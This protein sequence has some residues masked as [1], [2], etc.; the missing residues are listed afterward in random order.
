MK[1]N[2]RQKNYYGGSKKTKSFERSEFQPLKEQK[3]KTY[4]TNI[5]SHLGAAIQKFRDFWI[6]WQILI[7][8]L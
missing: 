8:I 1:F 4:K 2:Y 7:L 3:S 5:K 6:A